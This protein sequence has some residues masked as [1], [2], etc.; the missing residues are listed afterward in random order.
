MAW[1]P[2]SLTLLGPTLSLAGRWGW[3]GCCLLVVLGGH[4]EAPQEDVGVPQVAIGPPLCRLVSKF[5]SNG[6]ALRTRTQGPGGHG[7][8]RD[9]TQTAGAAPPALPSTASLMS[10]CPEGQPWEPRHQAQTKRG[11]WWGAP[12][13][14]LRP[15]VR[16]TPSL[17]PTYLLVEGCGFCEAPQQVVGVAQ[18]AIGPALGCPVAQLLHQGQVPP[19]GRVSLSCVPP[20]DPPTQARRC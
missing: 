12:A 1:R 4:V 9:P 17:P 13:V 3:E 11:G 2:G 19:G 6:Q 14:S 10:V 16:A 20:S 15:Y 8:A 7:A 18:V 5:L